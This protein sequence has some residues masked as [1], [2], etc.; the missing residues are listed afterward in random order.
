[1][2][3]HLL[4]LSATLLALFLNPAAAAQKTVAVLDFELIDDMA[5]MAGAGDDDD[6]RR[7]LAHITSLVRNELQASEHYTITDVAKTQALSANRLD[8][9]PLNEC[10]GCELDLGRKLGADWVVVGWVQ[11]VSNLILNINVLVTDV[12]SGDTV[13]Q[14]FVDLRGNNDKSWQRSTEYLLENILLQRMEKKL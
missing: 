5:G 8:T 12:A 6:E 4:F 14:A 11:K 1:M 9:Q 2:K 13:A 7:R 10:N 3:L